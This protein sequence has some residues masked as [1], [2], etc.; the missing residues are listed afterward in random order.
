[1][2]AMSE[3]LVGTKDM[4][5]SFAFGFFNCSSFKISAVGTYGVLYPEQGQIHHNL[6]S[7]SIHTYI[8]PMSYQFRYQK[9]LYKS[10]LSVASTFLYVVDETHRLIIALMTRSTLISSKAGAM[11]ST[12]IHI[13]VHSQ[14]PSIP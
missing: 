8:R 6:E 2:N 9:H 7:L 12:L 11:C 10:G 13:A 14:N 5:R 3:C 1:M 4:A